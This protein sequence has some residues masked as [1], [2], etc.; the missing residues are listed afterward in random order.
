MSYSYQRL[1]KTKAAQSVL[2]TG[3]LLHLIFSEFEHQDDLFSCLLINSL[4]AMTIVRILW[5]D[6]EWKFYESYKKWFRTLK[7]SNTTFDYA[8]MVQRLK[9]C[10]HPR[11]GKDKY[12]VNELKHIANHC[13]NVKHI[14]FYCLHGTFEPV[15]V[16][17]F[18]KILPGLTS[19][20]T[21][22]IW[23]HALD[24]T[25]MPIAEGFCPKLTSL[26]IPGN[27]DTDKCAWILQRIG[28][29]CP[30]INRLKTR[31][32]IKGLKMAQIIVKSFPNIEELTCRSVNYDGLRILLSGCRKLKY[33]DFT[34]ATELND[35]MAVS[36]AHIFPQLETFNLKIFGKNNFPQFISSWS[37]N[38]TK[39]RELHL[40]F[41]E[42]LSDESFI[43]ITQNCTSLEAI[44][45]WWCG[46][47]TDASF[48]ALA[49]NRNVALKK[50]QFYHVKDL[51]D[52]GLITIA[53]NCPKLQELHLVHCESLTQNSLVKV[54]RDCK[55]LVTVKAEFCSRRY[56]WQ[57]TAA[58]LFTLANRNR[59][60]LEVLK[61]HDRN[62]CITDTE[63]YDKYRF[64]GYLFE[65][66]AKR[67]PKLKILEL[68]TYHQETSPTSLFRALLKFKNL[69]SLTIYPGEDA[70]RQHL[71]KLQTH[72]R[73]KDVV[74]YLGNT[75]DMKAYYQEF[76]RK[77]RGCIAA[78]FWPGNFITM[79]SHQVQA[80]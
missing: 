27:G 26:E 57:M 8:K 61:F 10:P 52:D 58:F 14:E 43:P 11:C 30:R 75:E 24:S 64:D 12:N 25:L 66:L 33:F 68:H 50:L 39:L 35:E 21:E 17:M 77:N 34:F 16:A 80:M 6:P 79:G 37:Q 42:G 72:R 78:Q 46:G 40:S 38:Q 13:T 9:F 48:E 74:F 2:Q 41:G 56:N 20:K 28:E 23:Q 67:C 49:C 4:W 7:S 1:N 18:L 65:R 62:T 73:L 32:E 44:T 70:R 55:N 36:I 45:L 5:K 54:A 76:S 3:E 59:G 69:E 53:D 22:A 60:T 19:F 15:H 47:F 71:E 63:S 31:W 51:K 29:H